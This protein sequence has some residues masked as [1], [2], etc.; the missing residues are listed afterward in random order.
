M[1]GLR[2]LGTHL[3]KD[4]PARRCRF[5]M[6]VESSSLTAVD[7]EADYNNVQINIM[8]M[9]NK[10]SEANDLVGGCSGFGPSEV[11]RN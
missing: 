5:F 6:V 11:I 3:H 1:S 4:A 8:F 10:T 9:K 2:P 7:P